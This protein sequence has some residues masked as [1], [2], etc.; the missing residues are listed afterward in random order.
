MIIIT[1]PYEIKTVYRRICDFM[2]FWII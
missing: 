2:N 1:C